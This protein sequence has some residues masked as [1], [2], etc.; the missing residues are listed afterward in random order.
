VLYPL[1]ELAPELVIPGQGRAASLA[2]RLSAGDLEPVADW[3]GP[4]N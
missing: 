3:Q 1:A 4:A 2:A